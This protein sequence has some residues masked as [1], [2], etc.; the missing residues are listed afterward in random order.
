MRKMNKTFLFLFLRTV[1]RNL[2]QSEMSTGRSQ[3]VGVVNMELD[4][5]GNGDGSTER[6]RRRRQRGGK[7]GREMGDKR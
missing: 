3:R 1:R 2:A 6:K 5:V 7:R 4:Q